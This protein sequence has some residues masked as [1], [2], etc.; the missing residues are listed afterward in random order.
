MLGIP[1][2]PLPLAGI[3]LEPRHGTP[4]LPLD[5]IPDP[6]PQIAQLALRL[7]TLARPILLLPL[8]LQPLAGQQRPHELLPR[9]ERSGST[10]LLGAPG[11]S[12]RWRP[13]RTP[14]SPLGGARCFGF[15]F[16][17]VL[18]GVGAL[19]LSAV[20]PVMDPSAD[21]AAPVAESM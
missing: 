18:G 21:W 9:P 6:A 17:G 7:L 8:A 3:P 14:S 2:L 12:S 20:L 4:H 1:P 15:G 5:A 11:R 19:T 16:G 10:R 13:S